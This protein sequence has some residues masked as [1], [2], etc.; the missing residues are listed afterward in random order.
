MQFWSL[1]LS[2][3]HELKSFRYVPP[4]IRTQNFFNHIQHSTK[5]ISQDDFGSFCKFYELCYFLW[6][7]RRSRPGRGRQQDSQ[8]ALQKYSCWSKN[9]RLCSKPVEVTQPAGKLRTT[10]QVK[11]FILV[12]DGSDRTGQWQLHIPVTTTKR[13]IHSAFHVTVLIA[14]SCFYL[15]MN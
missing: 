3:S 5:Y 6:T 7:P 8:I 2:G 10:I 11:Q 9:P 4:S 12:Q 13:K 14:H 15:F 1:I